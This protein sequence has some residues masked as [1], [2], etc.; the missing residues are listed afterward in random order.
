MTEAAKSLGVSRGT[1]NSWVIAE[2]GLKATKQKNFA[3][4]WSIYQTPANPEP[5][6]A[7]RPQATVDDKLIE[8]RLRNQVKRLETENKDLLGRVSGAEDFRSSVLGLTDPLEPVTFQ[9]HGKSSRSRETAILFL[10]DLQWGETI[11]LG[12]MDGLNSYD[13]DIARSRLERVFVTA[14]ELMTRHWPADQDPPERIILVLGGDMI[15]GEIHDELAKSNALLSIPALKDCAAHIVS[16]IEHI[17]QH[18]DCPI[19]IISIPGNHGRTTRKPESKLYAEHSYDT[20]VAD[21]VELHFKEGGKYPD[22]FRMFKP[23]S[24]DAL[25]WIYGYRFLITHGDRIGSRGGAGF[26]GAA[27]TIARGFKKLVMDYAGRGIT[28]D[29]IMCGHFHVAL[30]LEEGICNGSLPGPSE[31]A[32]D[33]RFKPRPCSQTFL[34]VHPRRGVTQIRRIVPGVPEEGSLYEPKEPPVDGGKPRFRI[35]AIGER[36]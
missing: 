33:F 15:S 18:I 28:L 1:V 7:D 6:R 19:D 20:L 16:G 12:N 14:V 31:Y 17:R 9:R 24:G 3:P 36:A 23:I 25:I 30:E 22:W 13:A 34:T 27:A 5:A 8:H 4:D 21:L 2:E 11:N 35:P 26:V 10:S 29:F 32:R